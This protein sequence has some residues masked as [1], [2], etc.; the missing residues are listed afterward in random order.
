MP[1]PTIL[2]VDGEDTRRKELVRGLTGLGYEVIAAAGAEEGR[3]FAEGLAPGLVVADAALVEPGDPLGIRGRAPQAPTPS[4]RVLV[5]GAGEDGEPADGVVGVPAGRPGATALLLRV[6]TALLA[7]ELGLAAEPGLESLAG[8]LDRLPLLELLPMLQRSVLTGRL[9]LEGGI[10]Q[11]DEGEVVAAAAGDARGVKAFTRLARSARGPF[12][13]VLEAG[14][15]EREIFKDLLS[16]MAVAI[17]D[18]HRYE[19]ARGQLPALSSRMRLEMGPV[20]FATQFS[21]TQQRLLEAVQGSR[22]A[23]HLLD[24]VVSPDGEALADLAQLHRLGIVALEDAEVEV[25]VV[26]DS[27]AG[28]PAPLARSL[29]VALLPLTVIAGRR[30]LRDGTGTTADEL[31]RLLGTRAGRRHGVRVEPVSREEAVAAFRGLV[32]RSDVVSLHVSERLSQTVA[33]ARAGAERARDEFRE[34]RRDGS[35][36]VEVV[37]TAQVSAGQ[38]LVVVAAARMAGRRLRAHEIRARV[39]AM[40]GR[41]HTLFIGETTQPV[42]TQGHLG[43]LRSWLAGRLGI[44]PILGVVEGRIA[45]VDHVRTERAALPRMVELLAQ[46]VDPLRPAIACV[47]HAGAPLRAA[48]LR[49]LLQARL[50]LSEIVEGEIGAVVVDLLGPGCVAVALL[51]PAPEEEPLLAALNVDR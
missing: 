15:G 38:A 19:E 34:L 31:L 21:P 12:R 44:R 24:R 33:N 5:F 32:A 30:V 26:S 13:I 28:L 45:P 37:D 8:D 16:L 40:R 42:R 6:R 27:A 7:D 48:E 3:R 9:E 47:A 46:R 51:Q 41:V 50:D 49:H 23:W 29:R 25:R 36:E 17:E 20:F 2:V 14:G 4:P 1:R 22:T 18:H 10:L 39:E 43:E 35:P 11:L